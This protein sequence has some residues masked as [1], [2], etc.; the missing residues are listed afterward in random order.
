M[1]A[2]I[3][4]LSFSPLSCTHSRSLSTLSL[5]SQIIAFFIGK[6]GEPLQHIC[7]HGGVNKALNHDMN[8]GTIHASTCLV[9]GYCHKWQYPNNHPLCHLCGQLSKWQR[10][11]LLNIFLSFYLFYIRV[12]EY[13][14]NAPKE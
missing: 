10:N 12:I 14:I 1:A 9:V 7:Q 6:H 2:A 8:C 11:A 5:C 13:F 3:A 4:A